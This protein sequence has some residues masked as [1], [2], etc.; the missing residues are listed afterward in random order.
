MP[1][2]DWIGKK[3]VVNHHKEVPFHLLKCDPDL[4]VG[5]P[6][7]GNL[8]VQGD[9]L[10]ALKALL[11]YYAG[12]VKCIYI[13]PPYN[14]GNEK[15]VYN[16]NVNSP[17]IREWLGSVV[18]KEAEDLSRHDKWLCMM[19]PRLNLLRDFLSDEGVIF[20]SIDDTE[21]TSLRFLI[22]EIFGRSQFVG[23]ILWQK[24]TSPDARLGLSDAHEY[25]IVFAKNIKQLH[26][27]RLPLSKKQKKSYK[28]PD[29]DPRGPWVSSDY[30]AQGFRPNQMYEITSPSG[31]K[32]TPPPGNCWKNIESVF[33]EL[34]ADNRIWFG[35]NGSGVPRRKTFLSESKGAA[36][37]TWWE[38]S[39]V[40]HSQEAKKE[41]KNF[42]EGES[43]F[44]TPKPTRLIQRILQIATDEDSIVLDS[45]VGSGTTGQAVLAQNKEDGGKRKCILVEM[46]KDIC[47]NITAK[48]LKF[49]VEGYVKKGLKDKI[50]DI[51][52]LGGGFQYCYL[53]KTLFDN[54]GQI[55]KSVSFIELARF[56]FFKESGLPLS[57]EVSGKTPLIG[58]HNDAAIYLLYN[59][60]LGDKTPQGGNALTRAVLADL[61][62]HDGPKVVYG[63][64]CRVG[65][66]RLK[67]ENIIFRQIPY[68]LKVD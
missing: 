63:T 51:P 36:A 52:G 65:V 9:N 35:K 31:K 50:E 25:V 28:N 20:V 45:F 22:D 55:A 1:T 19:Y 6:E 39:E 34:V 61:P 26:L 3:A 49:V 40:G 47:A 23:N 10:L 5:D 16:D 18:G 64:S 13:D 56:V 38:N 67:Q 44:D 27:K 12:Q 48:R 43:P 46:D 41:I 7:S 59:G 33:L 15:W 58:T 14:T 2:L 57:D 11:P 30:S 29:N 42:M 4:S 17:E 68:E 24:R 21:V 62:P 54:T 53:G 60:I 32:V 66:T 37:W 8:L